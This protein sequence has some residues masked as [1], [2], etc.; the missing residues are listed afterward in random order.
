MSKTESFSRYIILILMPALALFAAALPMPAG[1]SAC[2]FLLAFSFVPSLAAPALKKKQPL[3]PDGGKGDLESKIAP[4]LM[5]SSDVESLAESLGAAVEDVWQALDRL[6]SR[7]EQLSGQA[8][9]SVVASVAREYSL[10]ERETMILEGLANGKQNPEIA[11]EMFISEST[12]KFHVGNVL[13]KLGL[14]N[15]RQVCEM[16][17]QYTEDTT[18]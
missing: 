5:A 15:R 17:S 11:Y 7:I 13:R 4:L 18:A 6:S 10:T 8:S 16:L 14:K 9:Q 3:E 2:F 12:V 1:L